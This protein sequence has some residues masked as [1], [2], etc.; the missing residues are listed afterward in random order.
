MT[1][2]YPRVLVL[3]NNS[4][5]KSNSNGRTLGNLFRGWPK[6]RVAQF[7]ISSDGP[8]FDVCDNYYQVRDLDVIK[9]LWNGERA[10]SGKDLIF[11]I[12]SSSVPKQSKPRRTALKSLIRNYLWNIGFWKGKQ[13]KQWINEFNP[14]LIVVQSGDS[15]F[16]LRL[17]RKVAEDR[18][19]PL[20]VY[21]T[22]GYL[23]FDH[24][25]L[26][27][28]FSDFFAF[29]WFKKQYRKEFKKTLKFAQYCIYLNDKL[30][31]DYQ[32]FL[33]H[34]SSVIYNSS[35]MEFRPKGQINQPPRISYLGNLGI[36]RHEALAEVGRLLQTISPDLK[37]D[38]YGKA[39]PEVKNF[40]EQSP[41][42][43]YCGLIS[44]DQ[45]K[46]VIYNSDIVMHVE[47]NDPVLNNELRYAFSTKIADSVCSGT[48]F[49]IYAPSNLACSQYI[50]KTGAGWHADTADR[51]REII[52]LIFRNEEI[53]NTIRKKAKSIAKQNHDS[54]LNARKMSDI[55]FKLYANNITNV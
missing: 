47:K 36:K 7:F 8:D 48:P 31:Q 34:K 42:V 41:G 25:F 38:V 4:F 46:E 44:Y 39:Y 6:E 13:F 14:D 5:S 10:V 2:D 28:H 43:N 24:N 18:K 30:E 52:N 20:V 9:S 27:H 51:L 37:I 32:N 45:V 3:S 21:N 15:A 40:F 22:E 50:V 1:I 19:A 11:S 29:P 23:F 33:P 16:M 55:L 17:A 35:D 12:Q 49:V 26:P 53:N 54:I